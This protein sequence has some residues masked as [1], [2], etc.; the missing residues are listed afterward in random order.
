[1]NNPEQISGIFISLSKEET[2]GLYEFL[3]AAGYESNAGGLKEY[4][5]DSIEDMGNNP[6]RERN[7]RL[8]TSINNIIDVVSK[9]PELI[10]QGIHTAGRLFASVKE[11]F[12][13]RGG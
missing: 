5:F 12:K 10:R 1:M 11:G 3:E 13:K 2:E 6:D 7:E 9:N 4:V 8:D